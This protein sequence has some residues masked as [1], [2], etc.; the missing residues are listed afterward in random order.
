MS[1][2]FISYALYCPKC[3]A[4]LQPV[5]VFGDDK[6]EQ[7]HRCCYCGFESQH[8]TSITTRSVTQDTV[9]Y[10]VSS[11]AYRGPYA[12]LHTYVLQEDGTLRQSLPY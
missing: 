1:A 11:T 3:G 4:E 10:L 5:S 2:D 8:M 12:Q 6:L 7:W 9:W